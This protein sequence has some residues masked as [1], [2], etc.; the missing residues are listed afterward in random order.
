MWCKPL[1]TWPRKNVLIKSTLS[2]LNCCINWNLHSLRVMI[3]KKTTE[4]KI[5]CTASTK[6]FLSTSYSSEHNDSVTKGLFRTLKSILYW[7][8]FYMRTTCIFWIVGQ[9][10]PF[11]CISNFTSCRSL[12]PCHIRSNTVKTPGP[13]V[14]RHVSFAGR[15]FQVHRRSIFFF[16]NN[17]SNAMLMSSCKKDTLMLK[18]IRGIII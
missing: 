4:H 9:C 10:F 8:G 3:I 15:R 1:C 7:S 12:W 5:G 17:T 16:L 18:P 14:I 11:A 2:M 13:M 6:Q